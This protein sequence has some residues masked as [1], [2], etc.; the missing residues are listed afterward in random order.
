MFNV[1]DFNFYKIFLK[2]LIFLFY[3][4]HLLVFVS[5]KFMTHKSN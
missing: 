5:V 3:S 2:E 1:I 4:Q